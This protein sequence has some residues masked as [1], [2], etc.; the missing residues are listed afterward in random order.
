LAAKKKG[1]WLF[2][3]NASP[4]WQGENRQGMW[5]MHTSER[6]PEASQVSLNHMISN[7]TFATYSDIHYNYLAL[8]TGI[9]ARKGTR[10]NVGNMKLKEVKKP[11][12]RG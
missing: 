1:H 9:E 5:S 6:E 7:R 11:R 10:T 3:L 4:L 12:G 2:T 8:G